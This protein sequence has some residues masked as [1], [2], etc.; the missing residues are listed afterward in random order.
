MMSS[1]RATVA[2]NNGGEGG[3]GDAKTYL[4]P[5]PH[6]TTGGRNSDE[7]A[8]NKPLDTRFLSCLGERNLVLLLCG[9]DAADNHINIREGSRQ[10]LFGAFEVAFTDLNSSFLQRDD[11]GLLNGPRTHEG[12]N[13]L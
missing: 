2:G 7:S 10:R 4:I 11:G 6:N 8:R 9:T 3:E 5:Q 13:L 12:V 1:S